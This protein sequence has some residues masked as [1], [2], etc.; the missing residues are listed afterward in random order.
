[1]K[2]ECPK[3]NHNLKC[4]DEMIGE[5]VECPH[6]KGSIEVPTNNTDKKVSSKKER[7]IT[8][9]NGTITSIDIPF[10]DVFKLV[11]Q[12]VLSL[13]FWV[14]LFFFCGLAAS[15]YGVKLAHF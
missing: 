1:M 13:F 9:E 11:R 8:C 2:F 15:Y 4:D 5:I 12:V 10:G 7:I 3:C 14:L 6:C